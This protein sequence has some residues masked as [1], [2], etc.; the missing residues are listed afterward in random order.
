MESPSPDPREERRKKPTSLGGGLASDL[1]ERV[2][3]QAGIEDGIGNL[4]AIQ[5]EKVRIEAEGIEG[6]SFRGE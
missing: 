4:V 3:S 1:G 2:L 5:G 6:F